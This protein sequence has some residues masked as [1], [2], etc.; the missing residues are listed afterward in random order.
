HDG[1][2]DECER[3]PTF[4]RGDADGNGAL[5]LTDPVFLL[6]HLFAGGPAPGCLEAADADN[7]GSL[8][9]TDAIDLLLYL[10]L[11]RP[12]PAAPGPPPAAC[13]ADPD[14]PGSPGDI[15][16]AAYGGC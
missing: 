3:R 9:V 15:G 1:V 14:A 8:D 11:A 2:P 4:H 5:D 10:F 16:C 13:G 6:A 12:P 7:G